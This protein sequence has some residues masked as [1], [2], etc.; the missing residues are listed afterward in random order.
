[1]RDALCH[2]RTLLTGATTRSIAILP[3]RRGDAPSPRPTLILREHPGARSEEISSELSTDTAS[4]RPVLHGL[5]DEGKITVEGKAR[6]T[7]YSADE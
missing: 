6:A 3:G 1:M 4:L 5:R 7:K 2:P